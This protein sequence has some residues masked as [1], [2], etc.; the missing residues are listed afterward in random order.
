MTERTHADR[1]G[2]RTADR[3]ATRAA[4]G[5]LAVLLLAGASACGE[6]AFSDLIT[7]PPAPA[8]ITLDPVRLTLFGPADSRR[9]TATVLDAAG[10]PMSGVQVGFTSS[11][12]GVAVVDATGLV[13]AVGEGSATI[14]AA[15]GD[16]ANTA[17][18][19]VDYGGGGD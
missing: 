1:R 17:E 15:A 14:T 10:R 18:V 7:E 8:R 6:N 9:I 4:A 5:L 11:A 12:P 3:K 16:A 13:Q 19:V 2:T